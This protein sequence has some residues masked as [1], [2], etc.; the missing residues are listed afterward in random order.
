MLRLFYFS[1]VALL[2][3]TV[4]F[5]GQGID[6]SRVVKASCMVSDVKVSFVVVKAHEYGLIRMFK[7]HSE[8]HAK[9]TVAIFHAMEEAEEWMR[10]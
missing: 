8:F 10:S 2:P 5:S 1:Q 3:M 9:S 6:L 4:G 7:A